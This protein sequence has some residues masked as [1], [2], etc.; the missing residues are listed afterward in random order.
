MN[1]SILDLKVD[2]KRIYGTGLSMGVFGIL[3]LA[4]KVPS[5]FTAIVAIC[6]NYYK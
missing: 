3:E 5:L 6:D 2:E 1:Y 4:L